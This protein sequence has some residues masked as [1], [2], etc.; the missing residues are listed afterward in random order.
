MEGLKVDTRALST[1]VGVTKGDLRGCLNTLQVSL[2][3]DFV[4]DVRLIILESLLNR[5]MMKFRRL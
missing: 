5:S 4:G 1:L 3:K 2:L